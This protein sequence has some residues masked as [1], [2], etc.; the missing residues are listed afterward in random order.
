[1]ERSRNA[2]SLHNRPL[3][4]GIPINLVVMRIRDALRELLEEEM[5]THKFA[6]GHER[7][8]E[9]R[10]ITD[11]IFMENKKY[12]FEGA[13]RSSGFCKQSFRLMNCVRSLDAG[14][15]GRMA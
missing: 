4:A 6:Q 7:D 11:S 13:A 1:M 14:I 5:K 9:A 3:I 8:E 12:N 2:T 10:I 15:S